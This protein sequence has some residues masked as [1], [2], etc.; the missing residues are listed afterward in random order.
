MDGDLVLP[1]VERN[2]LVA[3]FIPVVLG[4]SHACTYCIIP[5][6]RGVERS[7]PPE[8]ILAEARAMAAQGVK[9]ITLLGQ[10]V[11]R[12]GKDQ[13]DYPNL[14][15]L[16]ANALDRRARAHTVSDLSSQ[17]DDRRVTRRRGELAQSLPAY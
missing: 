12:Y 3:G 10:I 6:R 8:D 4:C 14:A 17:L 2:H 1:E 9:E 16:L 7:R 13:A 11:D 5:Y 15:G